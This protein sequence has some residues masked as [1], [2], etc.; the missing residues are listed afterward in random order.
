MSF[1]LRA[2]VKM[3]IEKNDEIIEVLQCPKLSY[4]FWIV[5]KDLES[6]FVNGLHNESSK[7]LKHQDL[8]ALQMYKNELLNNG[9]KKFALPT[10]RIISPDGTIKE[11]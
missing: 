8:L 3:D 4:V 11:I 5:N 2:I 7:K 10:A 6:Y 9:W 1:S